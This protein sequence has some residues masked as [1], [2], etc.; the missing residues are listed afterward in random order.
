MFLVLK[1]PRA[2]R[3]WPLVVGVTRSGRAPAAVVGHAPPGQRN[4]R[5]ERRDGLRRGVAAG[6]TVA[7]EQERRAM[8]ILIL[9]CVRL[10]NSCLATCTAARCAPRCGSV[11]RRRPRRCLHIGGA[12]EARRPAEGA[13][14]AAVAQVLSS[15]LA[16]M[17]ALG[18]MLWGARRTTARASALSAEQALLREAH[19]VGEGSRQTRS[20][21]LSSPTRRS[22][23][24]ATAPVQPLNLGRR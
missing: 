22:V 3:H 20:S 19:E 6:G 18:L 16:T 9:A 7:R 1:V 14:A 15:A 10:L 2:A 4:L 12:H 23:K 8:L 21:S 24:L 13:R 17:L 5:A 11:H